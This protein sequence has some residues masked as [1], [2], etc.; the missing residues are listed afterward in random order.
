MGLLILKT[1][2][3]IRDDQWRRKAFWS[4]GRAV[5]QWPSRTETRNL[6]KINKNN[7]LHFIWYHVFKICAQHMPLIPFFFFKFKILIFLSILSPLA[8]CCQWRQHIAPPASATPPGLALYE[9][10]T[11]GTNV[12]KETCVLEFPI[13]QCV[14]S[15][16]YNLVS[17]KYEVNVTC[18]FGSIFFLTARQRLFIYLIPFFTFF[19]SYVLSLYVHSNQIALC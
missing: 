19:P 9:S 3:L 17:H 13:Q 18:V 8:L 6:K 7:L 2:L 16:G 5:I 15:R 1:L 4:P 10:V 14:T 12:K 11:S